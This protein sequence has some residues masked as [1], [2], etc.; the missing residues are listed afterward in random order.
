[1]LIVSHRDASVVG[2]RLD[3]VS[4]DGDPWDRLC[5]LVLADPSALMVVDM[6][7]DDDVRRIMSDPLIAVGSDNG[8]PHGLQHPRTWGCFPR[9]LGTYVRETGVLTWEQAIRKMTSL[10]ART[11]GHA[12][13]GR[14]LPGMVAD[15]CVF[16]PARIGHAGTYLLPDVAPDG[17]ELVT[18]AGSVALRSGVPSGERLGRVLRSGPN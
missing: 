14:L 1:V 3:A 15:I 2:R 4:G 8:P 12:G 18:L 13:R 17:V 9:V 10:S 7:S 5:D 6:M 16:D 11:F